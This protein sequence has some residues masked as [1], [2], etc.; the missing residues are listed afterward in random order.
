MVNS[1]R[2]SVLDSL[3]F[4]CMC[5]SNPEIQLQMIHSDNPSTRVIIW[6]K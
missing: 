6:R 2:F 1:Y 5:A 3:I 4:V